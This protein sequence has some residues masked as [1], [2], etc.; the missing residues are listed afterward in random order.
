LELEPEENE[1]GVSVDMRTQVK[2]TG[3][4]LKSSTRQVRIFKRSI[5]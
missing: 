1:E 2:G 4:V 5:D 3:V